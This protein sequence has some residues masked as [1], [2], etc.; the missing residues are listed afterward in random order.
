MSKS[1]K[2]LIDEAN[3]DL[4]RARKKDRRRKKR[5]LD[6]MHHRMNSSG[7]GYHTNKKKYNRKKHNCDED[8]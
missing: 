5:N 4:E 8:Y 2:D 6:H 3:E 7:T 1:L